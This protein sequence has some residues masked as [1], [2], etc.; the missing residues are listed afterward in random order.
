MLLVYNVKIKS[1]TKQKKEKK[2]QVETTV[3]FHLKWNIYLHIV[4]EII[5]N[6]PSPVL[7]IQHSL[8][9][10]IS[11]TYS[12]MIC[13][14]AISHDFVFYFTFVVCCIYSL[15]MQTRK[16]TNVLYEIVSAGAPFHNLI[17]KSRINKK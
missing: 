17:E 6:E 2:N 8:N 13:N 5:V 12:W 15:K 1:D 10:R 4:Y 7:S 11:G 16:D 14:N 9:T 3:T